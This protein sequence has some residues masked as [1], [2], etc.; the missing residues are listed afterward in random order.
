MSLLVIN[1]EM[2]YIDV[3]QELPALMGMAWESLPLLQAPL[4]I[5]LSDF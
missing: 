3:P 2:L 1:D 4:L 5:S